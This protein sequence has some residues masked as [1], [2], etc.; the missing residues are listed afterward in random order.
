MVSWKSKYMELKRQFD[1]LRYLPVITNKASF[2]LSKWD[3]EIGST[4]VFLTLKPI[5]HKC[6]KEEAST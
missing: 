4:H 1:K 6:K 2:D 5:L 3:I